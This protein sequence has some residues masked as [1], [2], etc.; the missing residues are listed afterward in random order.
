MKAGAGVNGE[1]RHLVSGRQGA[2]T[3]DVLRVGLPGS[4]LVVW[5]DNHN[6]NSNNNDTDIPTH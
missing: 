3:G 2:E 5:N 1:T 6:Y 4:R